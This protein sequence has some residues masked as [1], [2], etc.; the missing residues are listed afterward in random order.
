MDMD[1]MSNV[2]LSLSSPDCGTSNSKVHKSNKQKAGPKGFDVNK[3]TVYGLGFI[4]KGYAALQMLLAVMD[5]PPPMTQ[6][7]FYKIFK[8]LSK[9]ITEVA[10]EIL[11]DAA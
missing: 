3:R 5:M 10:K 9:A 8:T 6:S 4:G 11:A 7:N 2:F 1:I